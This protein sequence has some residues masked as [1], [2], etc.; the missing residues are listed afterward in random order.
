MKR[1]KK[2]KR[3]LLVLS[4]LSLF[5]A[6][7]LVSAVH[8]AEVKLTAND[9][10]LGDCFGR[11]VA[12]AGEYA[13]IGAPFNDDN[14]TNSGSAYI[15]TW[16]GSSWIEEA[17]LLAGDGAEKDTFGRSVA[18]AG[19]YALIGA[20]Y[21]DDNGTN[22]GSAYIFK[23]NGSSWVE[24]AKL[25]ASDG[26]QDD[27]FGYSVA[28]AGDYALVGA[29]GDSAPAYRS[30]SAY[31]FKRNGSSWIEEAKLLAGDGAEY[32]IFGWSVAIAGEY[33]LVGA[34]GDDDSGTYSGSAYIFTWNGSSWIE[35][36]KLLAGDGAQD[37]NFGYSVAIAGDYA[38]VG[39]YGD[40]DYANPGSAYIF[41]WNGSS[42][43]EQ[44][45]LNA[46]DGAGGDQFGVSVA[47]AGEYALVGACGDDDSAG[48][49]Y[50]FT[51]NVSSWIEEAKLNASDGAGG[52]QFGV[53]VAITGE[54][55]LVGAHYDDD[56][57][58]NSGSA[59]IYGM[60]HSEDKDD[61]NDGVPDS[62]DNCPL[63][64]NTDQTDTDSDGVG[65]VCDDDDD[66]DGV[67]DSIDNCPLVANTDQTDTDSDGVGDVCDDDDDGDG[68][69]DSADNCPLVAN[70]DQTDT[71]SDGVGD[72]CDDDDDGD[73][74][75][76]STD[77]CPAEDATG[78]DANGDGCID[79][80]GGS[81]PLIETLVAEGLID[82]QLEN[83]LLSKVESAEKMSDKG[84]IC[85]SVNQLNALKNEVNA[86]RG[87][88]I[89]NEA[90]DLII[91]YTNNVIA[92]LLAQ[93]PPGTSC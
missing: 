9:S 84:N 25:L 58:V 22:S 28:I 74:V 11:S 56:S 18:I 81:E 47:I 68:V 75:P 39:A 53:S 30:G 32:D 40:D 16:N 19:D 21:D 89:S 48:S 38:L 33:A 35:E 5:L 29:P 10:A 93:L 34:C 31:I 69:P 66:N 63:V 2:M 7:S 67:P 46:S 37:D 26:A 64:A 51:R 12:I 57:G 92:Q 88:K 83:S 90:A 49:A 62:I 61:D 50:I 23:R 54:Y 87:K 17:K 73:G 65:D 70:T 3:R 43:T 44:A 60:D 8:A 36:A 82:T 85:A 91:E 79:N 6:L 59:Y 42:W 15:F 41:T 76:D 27:N 14:G 20:P 71:D 45:K 77:S 55:A 24:E 80:V 86:Q 78:F 13:L 72:V 4:F 1:R 52:D